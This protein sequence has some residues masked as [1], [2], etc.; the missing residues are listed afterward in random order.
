MTRVGFLLLLVCGF[1]ATGCVAS[2]GRTEACDAFDGRILT[3]WPAPAND[4]HYGDAG[5]LLPP[6]WPTFALVVQQQPECRGPM[7]DK[8]LLFA[9][10]PGLRGDDTTCHLL[11]HVRGVAHCLGG[12]G[13]FAGMWLR[14]ERAPY[15]DADFLFLDY[16][17]GTAGRRVRVFSHNI[18][19]DVP[20]Q[21]HGFGVMFD[22]ASRH[23]VYVGDVD[24]DGHPELL[25]STE[26]S[27]TSGMPDRL[28]YSVLTFVDRRPVAL[29]VLDEAEV[30]AKVEEG[31]LRPL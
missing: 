26:E 20:F 1:L 13:D 10:G 5:Q 17:G 8:V 16:T 25:V 22:S 23:G 19:Y 24:A 18:G 7:E 30:L 6:S 4:W 15:F 27:N 2:V 21:D 31:I 11:A 28:A 14:L 9:S 29:G 3:I 12:E